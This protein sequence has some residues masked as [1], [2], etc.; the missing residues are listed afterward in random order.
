MD[1]TIEYYEKNANTFFNETF[2]GD[3]DKLYERFLKHVPEN[4]YILDFGCGSGRDSK[5]FLEKG[6]RVKAIDGSKEMCNLA[7]KFINQKV[8]CMRFDE[9]NEKEEYDAIWACASILH[10][11]KEDLLSIINKMVNALKENGVMFISFKMGTGYD[12]KDGRYYNYIKK[13]DIEN[14]IS[15]TIPLATIIDYFESEPL[16]KRVNI[17]VTWCDFIIKK[18]KNN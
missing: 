14:I 10:V 1:S 6:Y 11:K 16:T 9:L 13:E 2:E 17:G 3:F 4:G 15:K 12:I 7:S 8:E 18:C 5:A